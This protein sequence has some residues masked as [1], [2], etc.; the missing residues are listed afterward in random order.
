MRL[1]PLLALSLAA[2]SAAGPAIRIQLVTGGH[3]HEISFYGV[4]AGSPDFAINVNPHPGAFHSDLRKS[5]DV[6]C[7]PR[8]ST[9][10]SIQS[11]RTSMPV[12]KILPKLKNCDRPCVR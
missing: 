11:F 8:P 9:T 5:T 4:F 10:S 6:L 2:A 3:D 1:V 7:L 12:R